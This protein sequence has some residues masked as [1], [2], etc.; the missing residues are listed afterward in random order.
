MNDQTNQANAA[1]KT[2]P[3]GMHVTIEGR[4]QG[5]GFRMFVQNH[6]SNLGL[7]GWVR[8]KVE[9][10]VEIWAEGERGKL[11]KFAAKLREGPPA[12]VITNFDYQWKQPKSEYS[13]FSVRSTT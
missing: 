9:G 3:A 2:E 10:D 13:R 4:V 12:A 6:A 1:S 11:E 5:V 8:N 7:T